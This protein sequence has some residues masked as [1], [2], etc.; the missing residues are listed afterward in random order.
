MRSNATKKV[1]YFWEATVCIRDL[2]TGS[3]DSIGDVKSILVAHSVAL[4]AA[5]YGVFSLTGTSDPVKLSGL[6]TVEALDVDQQE[7][8]WKS[9]GR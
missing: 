1:S 2:K 7:V 5:D 3:V 9:R 4:I 8:I 6:T